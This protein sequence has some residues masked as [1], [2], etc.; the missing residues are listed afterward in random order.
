MP[1]P[2]C[3]L[4]LRLAFVSGH[5]VV[6]RAL[7][8]VR[9]V[10]LCALPTYYVSS[11]RHARALRCLRALEFR[12]TID[13]RSLE[14]DFRGVGVHLPSSL[15]PRCS[16]SLG[17]R[18]ARPPLLGS[19]LFRCL[20]ATPQRRTTSAHPQ[21]L[22]FELLWNPHVDVLVVHCL[23]HLHRCPLAHHPRC[24]LTQVSGAELSALVGLAG[25]WLDLHPNVVHHLEPGFP[26][27]RRL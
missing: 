8:L 26:K 14:H 19:F 24:L 18:S 12:D 10:A 9:L 13:P 15:A 22:F 25:R 21:P 7:V 4:P 20:E 2:W 1:L 27:R 6:V 11:L 23:L 17:R 16:G 5:M 3:A